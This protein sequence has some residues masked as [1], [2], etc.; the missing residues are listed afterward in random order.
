MAGQVPP[1]GSGSV[2]AVDH[3]RQRVRWRR[4]DQVGTKV[5][6]RDP[7][8]RGLLNR[9]NEVDRRRLRTNPG[10]VVAVRNAVR[11]LGRAMAETDRGTRRIAL[12]TAG[13]IRAIRATPTRTAPQTFSQF[14]IRAGA[15]AE[16][17]PGPEP[18]VGWPS[19]SVSRLGISCD[20][21]LE[22][23]VKVCSLVGVVRPGR[24]RISAPRI[25]PPAWLGVAT[26]WH[27]TTSLNTRSNRCCPSSEFEVT[28]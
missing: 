22:S 12:V 15:S 13:A 26:L 9:P 4:P 1:P 28:T 18:A 20:V 2:V 7:A 16:P 21:T 3:C 5:D 25:A 11:E 23:G 19:E 8:G 24:P 6:L 17:P 14:G 10:L 27:S